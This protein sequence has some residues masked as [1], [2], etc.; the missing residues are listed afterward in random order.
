MLVRSL[1]VGG[2]WTNLYHELSLR[3][4]RGLNLDPCSSYKDILKR[5][6]RRF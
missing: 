3:T 1:V 2:G 6:T 5:P 4:L